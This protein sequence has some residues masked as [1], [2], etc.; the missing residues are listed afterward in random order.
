MRSVCC[1]LGAGSVLGLLGWLH[2]ARSDFPLRRRAGGANWGDVVG[3]LS[4][5]RLSTVQV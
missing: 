4:L 1:S 3:V 2:V 5:F